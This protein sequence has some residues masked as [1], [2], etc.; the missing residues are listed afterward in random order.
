[1]R[2][3]REVRRRRRGQLLGLSVRGGDVLDDAG[4]G[5]ASS[6]PRFPVPDD[7]RPVRAERRA[8]APG[9]SPRWEVG[10]HADAPIGLLG[11]RR[12]TGRRLPRTR[13]GGGIRRCA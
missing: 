2:R 7:G 5:R 9:F 8:D 13:T 1:L 10:C 6:P 4:Y 3:S 12:P 11:S